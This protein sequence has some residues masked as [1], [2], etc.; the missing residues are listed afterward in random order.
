MFDEKSAKLHVKK[1]QEIVQNPGLLSQILSTHFSCIGTSK[2]K[3]N[4]KKKKNFK[5]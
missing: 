3:R 1:I 4:D 2:K 5:A